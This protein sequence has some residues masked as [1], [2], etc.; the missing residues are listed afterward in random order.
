MPRQP[1]HLT[2]RKSQT[3]AGF[4]LVLVIW[5]IGL[6]ALLFVTY[7]AAARYRAIEAF[8]LTERTRAEAMASTG[9]NLA[10]LDVLAALAAGGDRSAR[11]G[12]DGTPVLCRLGDGS[13]LAI[14]VFDES[15]KVD[16]NTAEPELLEVLLRSV[17]SPSDASPQQLTK[18]IL[19]VREKAAAAASSEGPAPPAFRSIFELDQIQGIGR[20]ALRALVPLVT[21]HSRSPGVNPRVASADVIKALTPQRSGR[22]VPSYFVADAPGRVFVIASEARTASGA[23]AAREA[24]VEFSTEPLGRFIREWRDSGLRVLSGAVT[25]AGLAPC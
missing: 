14:A 22:E 23:S 10:V 13:P 19:A 8:S 24:V 11:F 18:A 5:G 21:V 3:E 25:G 4:A 15:G 16:L 20:D 6:I 7:I 9:I 17:A 1:S 2:G 12:A